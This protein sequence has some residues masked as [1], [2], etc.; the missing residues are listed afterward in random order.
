MLFHEIG[1]RSTVLGLNLDLGLTRSVLKYHMAIVPIIKAP[2][3]MLAKKCTDLDKI[4]NKLIKNLKETLD[5]QKNPVGA[6]LAAPQIG[7]LKRVCLVRK[8]FPDPKN[9]QE[10]LFD[11]YVLVNPTIKVSSRK[12]TLDWEG[13]LSVPDIYGMVKRAK[14]IKIS[15]LDET[16]NKIEFSASGLFARE[17][18]HEIDHLDGIL[19]TSKVIGKKHSQKEL[20]RMYSIDD[21]PVI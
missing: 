1:G 19:F 17:I 6:G 14:K 10:E 12:T 4:D 15:A 16:G 9:P 7:V 3:P 13:C 11:E 20:S 21:A 8:F 5:K 18:Q 2:N